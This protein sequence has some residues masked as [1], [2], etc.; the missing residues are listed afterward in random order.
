MS[1]T[2]GK[3]LYVILLL[4]SF[5]KSVELT[6]MLCRS[7]LIQTAVCVI[8]TSLEETTARTVKAPPEQTTASGRKKRRI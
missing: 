8:D 4:E 6:S 2:N 5:L 7:Y 3:C 1:E